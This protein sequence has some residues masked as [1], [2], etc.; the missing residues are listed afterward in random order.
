ME[1]GKERASVKGAGSKKALAGRFVGEKATS[2]VR[3]GVHPTSASDAIIM[4]GA[5]VRATSPRQS[6]A[7]TIPGFERIALPHGDAILVEVSGQKV[8]VPVR[9]SE[10][11]I[12]GVVR[13]LPTQAL[14]QH[15]IDKKVPV[16]QIDEINTLATEVLESA[17]AALNWLQEPNVATDNKA[18]IEIIGEPFGLERVKSLLL[19][20][21][22]GVLA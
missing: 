8:S 6:L 18:P 7:Q 19:R 12:P 11:V 1:Q 10:V 14:V 9:H 5:I 2:E 15:W 20:I 21:E 16:S 3:Q 4:E 17:D 22:Y 13:S